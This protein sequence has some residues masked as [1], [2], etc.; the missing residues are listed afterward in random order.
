M[1]LF[2]AVLCLIG[3][4]VGLP[5]GRSKIGLFCRSRQRRSVSRPRPQLSCGH[6]GPRREV[7]AAVIL[8]ALPDPEPL[9]RRD[10][11]VAAGQRSFGESLRQRPQIAEYRGVAAVG[12]ALE[13][14]RDGM[15]RRITQWSA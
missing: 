9:T 10:A 13:S 14:P 11:E 15:K 1:L 7:W 4:W 3:G 8:H 6:E 2:L 5:Y 12:A